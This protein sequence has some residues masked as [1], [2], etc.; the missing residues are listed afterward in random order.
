MPALSESTTAD[1]FKEKNVRVAF[2]LGLTL[3]P[4]GLLYTTWKGALTMALINVLAFLLT[5]GFGVAITWP[6]CA[7]WGL[8]AARS[9]NDLVE[10]VPG[11]RPLA[12]LEARR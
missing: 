1:A 7:I 11:S 4:F 3:G 2:I 5:S 6:L 9:W 12:E 8:Q 10:L